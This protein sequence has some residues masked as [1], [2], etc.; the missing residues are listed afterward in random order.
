MQILDQCRDMYGSLSKSNRN[1][2]AAAL[3]G[4]DKPLWLK[5][6]RV[7][8]A[9]RPIMTLEMA[10]KQVTNKS[11]TEIPDPFT[12]Y[13]ALRYAIDRQTRRKKHAPVAG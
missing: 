6:K 8:I 10:I 1:L 5:V 4:M 3:Q 7:V 12:V 9:N 2:L 11:I 13:R